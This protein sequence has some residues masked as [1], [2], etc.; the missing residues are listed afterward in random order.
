MMWS[1]FKFRM[2]VWNV[3]HTT[4]WKYRTQKNRHLCTIAQLCQAISLQLR[5]VPTIGKNLLNSNISSICPYGELCPLEAEINWQ[6]WDTRVNFNGFRVF[7][8]FVT[9]PTSLNRDQP[10]FAWCL[11]ICCAVHCIYIFWDSCCWIEFCYVQNSLCIQVLRSPTLAVLL[12]GTEA[13][14]ISQTL[15]HGTTNGIMEF[16]LFII[17]N[18]G[19]HLYSKGGHHVGHNS[20][21]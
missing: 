4:R 5:H 1:S 6:V 9:A 16:L 12:H 10:N 13:V 3:L 18:R 8:G 11:A 2:L 15:R 19:R 14:G 17:L 20:I 7:F 21:F